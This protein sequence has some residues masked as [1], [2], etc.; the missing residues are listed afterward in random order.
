M[1]SEKIA[2]KLINLSGKTEPQSVI[3]YGF[4]NMIL[5]MLELLEIL[6][7]SLVLGMTKECLI[8]LGVFIPI[9]IYAGGH[10]AKTVLLCQVETVLLFCGALLGCKYTAINEVLQYIITFLLLFLIICIAPIENRNRILSSNEKR[11]FKRKAFVVFCITFLIF[12]FIKSI[13][14]IL[15]WG[16]LLVIATMLVGYVNNFIEKKWQYIIFI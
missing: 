8:M 6:T 5:A 4:N 13:R 1:N 9:R 3:V 2:K 11:V 16:Y 15:V 12:I 7:V 14:E 10:H